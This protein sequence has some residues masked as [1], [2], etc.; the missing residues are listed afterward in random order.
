MN[1]GWKIALRNLA[2][3]KRRNLATGIAIAAGF[4][5]LLALGGFIYRVENYLRVYTIYASRIGHVTIYKKD[6]LDKYS[7]KPSQYS[8]TEADQTKIKQ[9]LAKIDNI[10]MSG[11]QL[12]GFGLV[13]NGC[14]T[15]PFIATGID[16]KLDRRLREHPEIK[17]WADQIKP[18]TKGRGLWEYPPELGA[19]AL[20]DGLARILHKTH[21]HD[22]LAK[23]AKPVVVVDC[24]AP[25]AK[26]EIGA[27][28]NVQ[29]A[30]GSWTGMMSAI[31][32]EI[33]A[34]YNTGVTETNN[35]AILTSIDHL[36]KLYDTNNAAYWSVW[37]KDGTQLKSGVAEIRTKLRQAGLAVDVYPW[38]TDAMSPMY[39]G[40][41]AFLYTLVSFITIVLTV[42]IVFS[43]FNAATMTVIERS[44][45]I[46]MM[47]SLGFKRR[48]IRGFFFRESLLLAALSAAAGAVVAAVG[49]TAVN[50]SGVMLH[51]PGVVN[52]I[53]LFID[54]SAAMIF[55]ALILIIGLAL[56]T[57]AI[58]IRGVLK[59]GI[60]QLLMGSQR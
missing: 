19:V 38:N 29:L 41:M 47:R 37:L 24:N 16:P 21:T 52:G 20:S 50:T 17:R 7:V 40:T 58:A 44:Q 31:D 30:A 59:L 1:G 3:N 23:N 27:D 13:G 11:P 42:V 12:V 28:A 54:P 51:P 53:P 2:R 49:I 35:A 26:A 15:L 18:Y 48:E 46:G 45:E 60:P 39:T 25:N 9:V 32:G 8:L 22:E 6:G 57:T 55:G 14:R 56:L 10:E 34:T 4:A 43:V 5:S 33:V 36:R